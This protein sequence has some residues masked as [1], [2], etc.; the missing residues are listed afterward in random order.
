MKIVAEAIPPKL[1]SEKQ[2]Q[3]SSEKSSKN[4]STPQY[5]QESKDQEQGVSSVAPKE[6]PIPPSKHQRLQSGGFSKE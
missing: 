3:Q 5:I 6:K 1:M 4:P 2:S